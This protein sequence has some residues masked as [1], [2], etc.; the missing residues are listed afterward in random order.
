MTNGS[1]V[2][3]LGRSSRSGFFV[4]PIVQPTRAHHERGHDLAGSSVLTLAVERTTFDEI[5]H[6]VG[7]HFG[8]HTE[9]SV[10]SQRGQDCG[11][12]LAD[13]G[14]NRGPVRH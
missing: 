14:L 3:S 9:I 5:N 8:V 7:Q 4:D 2:K 13:S 12:D 11:R 6:R 1:F 10:I